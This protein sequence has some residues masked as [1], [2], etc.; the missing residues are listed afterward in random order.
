MFGTFLAELSPLWLAA[1][2]LAFAAVASMSRFWCPHM[3]GWIQNSDP[4]SR[5]RWIL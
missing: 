4:W 2:L 5:T 1:S 3:T